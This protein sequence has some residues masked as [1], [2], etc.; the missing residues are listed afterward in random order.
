MS[1][2]PDYSAWGPDSRTGEP[3]FRSITQTELEAENLVPVAAASAN[4]GASGNKNLLRRLG[5]NVGDQIISS[6]TN[7]SLSLVVARS[8]PAESFGAFSVAFIVFQ[9][10]I[11]GTRALVG[12]ALSM[13]FSG[14]DDK[15]FRPAVAG[16]T[17][18]TLLIGLIAGAV[19]VLGG[20][21]SPG[22][23]GHV[24]IVM[25][26]GLPGLLLQDTWRM[27]F[28]A[29]LRPARAAANDFLWMVLQIAFV[30]AALVVDRKSV[31]IFVAI[32]S[33]TAA[34]AALFG[35]FQFSL[36][37]SLRKSWRYL[38]DQWDITRFLLAEQVAVQGAYQGVLLL[39]GVIGTLSEVGALRGAM[40]LLGPVGILAVSITAFGI[41]ELSRRKD[42]KRDAP[43]I[44]AGVSLVMMIA[45]V[46]WISIFL[47][48][49]DAAGRALLGASWPHARAVLIPT[50]VYQLGLC[51]GDGPS[52]VL[53]A[54]GRAKE[55]FR[56]HVVFSILLVVGALIGLKLGGAAGA[57][58][59]MG[60]DACVLAP[61]WWYVMFKLLNQGAVGAAQA[62][63]E[64]LQTPPT[65]EP[66][67]EAAPA[68]RA[69]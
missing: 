27:V 59:G 1:D 39:I 25:G 46:G 37:P 43:K 9:F 8:V 62:T 26:I 31:V 6:L 33:G 7:L 61:V 65:A 14:H 48:L 21:A 38:R 34:I 5:W 24:L 23:L 11:L 54:L 67:T 56:M 60:I 51:A 44:A 12:Q 45:S 13:R 15:T 58:L 22:L 28:F 10:G 42:L 36:V 68:S 29:Q 35:L 66:A 64:Q 20:I 50:L 63:A 17:G 4:G 57:A 69:S 3:I 53:Y 18:A 47:A 40:V 19:C 2:L 55:S 52:L 30:A 16:A 32:W 49:P 41:P